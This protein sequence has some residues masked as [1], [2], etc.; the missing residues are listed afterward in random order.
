MI[1]ATRKMQAIIASRIIFL[2][3]N[4]IILFLSKI[5]SFYYFIA[6]AKKRKKKTKYLRCAIT[7]Y[8]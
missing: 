7:G 4:D 2:N 3:V 8:R 5:F 6:C 1:L